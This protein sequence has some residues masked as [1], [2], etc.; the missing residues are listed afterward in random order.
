MSFSHQSTHV[1]DMGTCK[2]L[3]DSQGEV[4]IEMKI[5]Y[6]CCFHIESENTDVNDNDDVLP[7]PPIHGSEKDPFP[8]GIFLVCNRKVPGAG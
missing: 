4:T 2:A 7:L 1:W 8:H 5:D 6:W 3:S